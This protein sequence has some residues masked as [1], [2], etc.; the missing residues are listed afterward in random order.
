MSDNTAY[1]A[2]NH[3]DR[4]LG[5]RPPTRVEMDI[6]FKENPKTVAS[7]RRAGFSDQQ[8]YDQLDKLQ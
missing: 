5:H 3:A 6:L 8:I 4:S 1:Q 7:Y 2:I